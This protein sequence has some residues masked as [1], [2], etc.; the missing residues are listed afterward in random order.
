VQAGYRSSTGDWASL[1]RM[2]KQ[3]QRPIA[4]LAVTDSGSRKAYWS[5]MGFTAVALPA[6]DECY[7]CAGLWVLLD[8][9]RNPGTAFRALEIASS[10]PKRLQIAWRNEGKFETV[11]A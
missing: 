1:A 2:R 9:D 8:V 5:G 10:N 7:L 4:F 3:G 6:A 11:I